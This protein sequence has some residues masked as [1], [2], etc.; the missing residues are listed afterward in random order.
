MGP[1][2][3]LTVSVDGFDPSEVR[4]LWGGPTWHAVV[5]LMGMD[6]WDCS[7]SSADSLMSLLGF[8]HY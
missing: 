4:C 8:H 2:C 1:T 7:E 3:L 6:G 5:G